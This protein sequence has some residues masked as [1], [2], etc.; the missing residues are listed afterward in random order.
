MPNENWS[1][2]DLALQHRAAAQARGERTLP[3]SLIGPKLRERR[4]ALGITQ[5]SLAAQLGISASYLNLIEANKRSIGGSL[6]KRMAEQLGLVIDELDGAAERRLV[7]DLR[8]LAGEPLLA[9]LRLDL[10]SADALASGHA[11][12]GRALVTLHRAWLDGNRAVS[13]LSDRLNQDPFLGDAVHSM[14]SRVAAIRSSAEILDT[15]D[16]LTPGQRKR[17]SSIVDSESARLSDVAQ[18]LAAFFDKAHTRTR[19]ITPVEEVDDFIFEHDN[20]F[21]RLEEAA[22]DFRVAAAVGPEC[23]EGALVEHLR[24]VHSVEVRVRPAAELGAAA[25]RQPVAFDAE[26]RVLSIADTAAPATR[27]FQLVRLAGDLFHQGQAVAAQLEGSPLLTSEAAR[28]RAQ[29]VLSSYL[30]AAVLLPYDSFHDAALG[31]RYDIDYLA[32]RFGASVEQVCHRLVSLRRPGAEGIPFGMM[33]VDPAGF[34]TKRFPLPHLLLPRHGNACPLWAVYQAFQS[35][36]AIVRQLA[37]FPSGDRYLFIART[38]EKERRG[39]AMPRRLMSLMLACD[40]LHADKTVYAEG[41]DLSSAAP[42]TPVG[43]NCRL[44]TRHECAYREEDPIIDA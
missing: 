14:L 15:V 17:F 12:W 22:A 6:L 24:R 5:T 13:A 4:K 7:R 29:R 39:F 26:A 19:S 34:V 31:A 16:D 41:L 27:R 2:L 28:R 3:R 32:Q 36:G 30:A 18:A 10:A 38:V 35:P 21:P 20:H 9:E 1:I 42:A 23:S 8:E 11:G 25:S 43:A 37:D 40:A 44:C 33:R